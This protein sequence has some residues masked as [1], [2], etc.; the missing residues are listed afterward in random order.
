MLAHIKRKDDGKDKNEKIIFSPDIVCGFLLREYLRNFFVFFFG[1][2]LFWQNYGLYFSKH[3]SLIKAFIRPSH[4]TIFSILLQRLKKNTSFALHHHNLF[5]EKPFLNDNELFLSENKTHFY[6]RR[7]NW[8]FQ[9]VYET[10]SN[11]LFFL[12]ATWSVFGL[13]L[14]SFLIAN[15]RMEHFISQILI[16]SIVSFFILFWCDPQEYWNMEK[17]HL[18]NHDWWN[19]SIEKMKWKR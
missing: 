14:I 11:L 18:L 2:I 3:S 6:I 5:K 13:S 17:Q 12:R 4:A 10:F 9:D 8:K 7:T 19:I 16:L 15:S 1:N